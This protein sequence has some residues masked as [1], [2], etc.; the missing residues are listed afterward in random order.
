MDGARQ[1]VLR[2]ALLLCRHDV[3]GQNRQHRPVHRHADAHL[4][5]R[6]A[7]K[8][9]LHVLDAVDGH[10]GLAHV[11]LHALVVAV[12][13]SVGRE[14]KRHAQAL[15]ACGEVPTVKRVAF[16]RRGETRVLPDCPR[17]DGVHRGIGST[18]IRRHP[19][20]KHFMALGSPFLRRTELHRPSCSLDRIARGF[21]RHV[22]ER[23]E[24][25]LCVL[26]P[27]SLSP[28]HIGRDV[29]RP[30]KVG[31]LPLN[32]PSLHQICA[33]A[34]TA[35]RLHFLMACPG[36]FCHLTCQGLHRVAAFHHV[37]VLAE[38]R[39]LSEDVL[40]VAGPALGAHGLVAVLPPFHEVSEIVAP[41]FQPVH[42]SQH[43]RVGRHGVTEQGIARMGRV[44]VKAKCGGL[45]FEANDRSRSHAHRCEQAAAA[46]SCSN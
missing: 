9:A 3:E 42:A 30:R 41:Y 23:I 40:D 5:E 21:L 10:A 39:F 22:V 20:P 19:R 44:G 1:L 17:S 37:D 36:L 29:P 35:H 7:F 27:W 2:H 15:L 33:G 18:Q 34:P 6:D 11:A 12:V 28:G 25:C 13:A 46:Q 16:F 4:V 14:V 43:R 26:R 38:S 32:R 8:E 31:A 24:P 45:S